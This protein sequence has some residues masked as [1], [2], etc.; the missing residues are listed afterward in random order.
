[1]NFDSEYQK[2]LIL[3]CVQKPFMEEMGHLLSQDMFD[4]HLEPVASEILKTWRQRKRVISKSQLRQMAHRHGV[5]LGMPEADGAEFDAQEL[6]RF[7]CWKIMRDAMSEAHIHMDQGR[8]EKAVAVVENSRKKFP[9]LHAGMAPDILTT[10]LPMPVRKN[11][12]PTGV[13]GLDEPL[14]GGIGASEVAVILAPTSGGKTTMLVYLS[15]QAVLQGKNVYYVT[16][17]TPETEIHA[18]A[19]RCLLG[20]TDYKGKEWKALAKTLARKGGTWRVRE[21]SPYAVST[22]E[23]EHSIPPDTN[24]LFVDYADYIRPLSGKEGLDYVNLG[25]VYSELVS[26]GRERNIP[27]WTA[28]QVNRAAYENETVEIQD[29]ELSMRKMHVC[30]QAISINQKASE[31]SADEHGNCTASLFIGKNR[32]GPRYVHIPITINWSSVQLREGKWA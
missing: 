29:V 16:L 1:M 27:V 22:S 11:V 2:S 24:V 8:F 3:K 13:A 26:I 30:S 23:L 19:R 7:A 25:Q 6:H 32:F 31:R 5:K 20:K 10:D 17:D 18:K 4:D 9:E 14:G 28:S 21:Y 15:C 12:V